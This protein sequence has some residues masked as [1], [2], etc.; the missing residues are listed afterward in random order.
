MKDKFIEIKI[1]ETT[2][3]EQF[4]LLAENRPVR[5]SIVEN[6]IM[7]HNL[8]L[9]NPILVT[10]HGE[11]LDGQHRLAVAKKLQIPIYYKIA[12]VTTREHIALLQNGTQWRLGDHQ[13]HHLVKQNPEYEF[14]ADIVEKHGFSLFFVI[15]C[16][17]G[18][19]KASERFKSGEFQV[20]GNKEDLAK[21]FEELD[22]V[23]SKLTPLCTISD[24][25][26]I[27]IKPK[28]QKGLWAFLHSEKYNHK[29][30][31]HAIE[32]HADMAQKIIQYNSERVAY[33]N[34]EE[35]SK[36]WTH[37]VSKTKR[38]NRLSA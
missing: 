20:Q 8:L 2:N 13:C 9:D 15:G 19:N 30:L 5:G 22:Q 23:L 27:T 38:E 7:K 12:L 4:I 14:V 26:E 37:R 18:S 16:C 31:L 33:N 10:P 32:A 1:Y 25:E 17:D 21:K 11:V 36:R 35:L 3:Y 29:R 34:L 28:F 24:T 6:S